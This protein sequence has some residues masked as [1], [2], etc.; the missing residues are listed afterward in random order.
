MVLLLCMPLPGSP[1]QPACPPP[2]IPPAAL[3][4]GRVF[5]G[6]LSAAARNALVVLFA[7]LVAYSFQ[8]MGSQPFTLTGSI[9]R[10]LP[11]FRLPCFSMAAPN[12][13]VPFGTMVEVGAGVA[14][15]AW[16][17]RRLLAPGSPHSGGG[18]AAW[19]PSSLGGNAHRVLPSQDM[20]VGLA[21]VPLM[22]LLETV[23]IAKAFG[24]AAPGSCACGRG[25]G[26]RGGC[27][28]HG[29]TGRDWA[30]R[31]EPGSWRGL[32]GGVPW[33]AADPLPWAPPCLTGERAGGG[34]CVVHSRSLRG[35]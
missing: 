12:G 23:A 30:A 27:C 2:A 25:F 29:G 34:V 9:P 33:D 10:G 17:P 5:T 35:S 21:V 7:G 14:G 4:S 8:V 15:G 32:A 16:A 3:G 19:R 26:C 20:G 1:R 28:S 24:T 18:F 6:A 31:V 13:T 22:G 11:A